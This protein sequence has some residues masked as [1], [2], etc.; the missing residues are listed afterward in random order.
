MADE[1]IEMG[2]YRGRQDMAGK[3]AGAVKRAQDSL[4]RRGPGPSGLGGFARPGFGNIR[5]QHSM[6]SGIIPREAKPVP[7]I[8]GT[9]VG[10]AFNSAISRLME[11]TKIGIKANPLLSRVILATAGVLTHVAFK[12]NF[13]LG[14]MIGQFPALI[15]AGVS[16]GMDMILGET[17]GVHGLQGGNMGRV[18]QE[19]LAELALLRKRLEESGGQATAPK[20]QLPAAATQGQRRAA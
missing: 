19:A 1:V 6:L 7:V 5:D 20:G 18:N 3:S 12:K 10:V 4:A 11:S 14:F 2:S 13:T 9:T 15:D 17:A 8:L 16:A